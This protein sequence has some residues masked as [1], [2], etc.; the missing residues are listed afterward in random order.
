MKSHIAIIGMPW[1]GKS[2]T[3]RILA[4]NYKMNFIDL[5]SEVEKIEGKNLIEVM[6]EK[7][8]EYFRHME[9]EM[10]L[11]LSK[12]TVISPA[13]SIIYY[14]PAIKWLR[15]NATVFFLNT[16]LEIIKKRM[17]GNPKA[18]SDLKAEGIEGLFTKR[19]PMYQNSSDYVIDVGVKSTVEVVEEISK[20]VGI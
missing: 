11:G 2:T 9:S 1:S 18:V 15:D 10:L 14:E 16:P 20:L 12:P 5:D 17:E 13:G 6:N 7:G 4:E 3:A 8:A 19:F